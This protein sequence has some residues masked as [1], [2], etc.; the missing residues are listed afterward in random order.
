MFVIWKYILKLNYFVEID[1]C[2]F[3]CSTWSTAYLYNFSVTFAHYILKFWKVFFGNSIQQI[4]KYNE[5]NRCAVF[6][7][8]QNNI[9]SMRYW[10]FLTWTSFVDSASHIFFWK[11]YSP[12]WHIFKYRVYKYNELM[13]F[14]I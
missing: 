10:Y 4:W 8:S 11:K 9:F 14:K 3:K 1:F 12:A 2:Y 13:F 5:K 7:S 6:F